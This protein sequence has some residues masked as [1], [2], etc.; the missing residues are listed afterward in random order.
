M[1]LNGDL[2]YRISLRR[3]VVI[4]S[5]RSGDLEYLRSQDQLLREIRFN[6][7]HRLRNFSEQTLDFAP[8]YKYDR[9][10]D[11][12]DSSEKRRAPAWCD[13]ILWRARVEGR[14]LPT[15]YKRHEVRASDHRPVS[16][17]FEATV[18][19]VDKARRDE[20]KKEVEREWREEERR[21]L[22]NAREWFVRMKLVC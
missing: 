10:S 12:Y 11:V 17:T 7:G 9:R 8:T 6:K 20:V 21:S 18:K 3:D 1:Q 15:G 5:V 2:N 14:V 4:A 19:R 13:R 22:Q 16:A